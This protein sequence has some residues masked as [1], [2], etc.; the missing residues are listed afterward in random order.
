VPPLPPPPPLLKELMQFRRWLC[1]THTT[2]VGLLK[3]PPPT[4]SD[5]ASHNTQAGIRRFSAW[6]FKQGWSLELIFFSYLLVHLKCCDVHIQFSLQR[7]SVFSMLD[8]WSPVPGSILTRW[9]LISSPGFDSHPVLPPPM[10]P[11]RR[12]Y[13]SARS[14]PALDDSWDAYCI[15]NYV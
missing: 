8:C 7:S 4:G 3:N 14:D 11:R 9:L 2:T 15:I 13:H 1:G 6:P 5:P 12:S 10:Q